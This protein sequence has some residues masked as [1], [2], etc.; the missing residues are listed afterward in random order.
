VL[1]LFLIYLGY[2]ALLSAVEDQEKAGKLAAVLCLAGLVN[3]PIVHFSVEWWSTLHQGPSVLRA[4]GPSLHPSMLAPLL[5]MGGAYAA[6][7]A[8]LLLA[9]MRAEIFRRRCEADALRRARSIEGL[10]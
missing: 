2:L 7:F 8:A 4:G 3:L 9:N 1:I 5:I 10:A 6:A